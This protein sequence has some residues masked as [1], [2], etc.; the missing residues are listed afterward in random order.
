MIIAVIIA[1]ILSIFNMAAG[2]ELQPA[3]RGEQIQVVPPPTT[4][5]PAPVGLWGVPFAP[6]G[7]TGC[8]EMQ[9]YRIQWGL[10]VEFD[11][12][13]YR[14]SRCI[15]A[16][17]VKTFCCHGWWQMYTS[18]HLRDHRLAP[19]MAACGVTHHSDLNSDTPIE[20]QKQACA[21][22]ALWSA[23]GLDPWAA[24]R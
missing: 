4:T 20:K 22:S 15:N 7:L 23:V 16:D 8:D 12:I 5:I 14:E 10:P 17:H 13:G 3:E 1:T 24:T 21:A 18:L 2:G 6:E 19:M 9:F 11:R